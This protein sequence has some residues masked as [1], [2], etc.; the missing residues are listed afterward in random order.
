MKRTNIEKYGRELPHNTEKAKQTCLEKY[1]VDNASKL[2]E[3][4][5]KAAKTRASA[6][7][8]DGT[9]FDSMTIKHRKAFIPAMI[10]I[11]GLEGYA[12]KVFEICEYINL[13]SPTRGIDRF[14]G[15]KVTLAGGTTSGRILTIYETASDVI[16]ETW[17]NPSELTYSILGTF[18]AG[19]LQKDVNISETIELQSR[20][21]IRLVVK[22]NV[23]N[24]QLTPVLKVDTQIDDPK[25]VS[26]EF[27]PYK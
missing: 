22:V 27:N 20:N 2:R 1:G 14:S 16:T 10:R 19:G 3:T 13:Y 24:G 26:G 11:W 9:A 8:S 17:F 21:N 23:D 6:I 25:E 5:I 4:H 12:E 15:L 7:A 18:N